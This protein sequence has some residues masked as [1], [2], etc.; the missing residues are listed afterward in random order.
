[1]TEFFV[2]GNWYGTFSISS[3]LKPDLSL[4]SGLGPWALILESQ[5][6][7]VVCSETFKR[8]AVET[9]I[10]YLLSMCMKPAVYARGEYSTLFP[11][12]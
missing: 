2:I 5:C 10:S 4:I 8:L 12:S 3:Y 6:E 11:F 7:W 9:S 1:M